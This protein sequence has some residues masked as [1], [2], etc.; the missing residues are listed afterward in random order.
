[1]TD[2]NWTLSFSEL[3]NEQYGSADLAQS[4]LTS[5]AAVYS[6]PPQ[7]PLFKN[8]QFSLEL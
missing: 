1:M 8:T 3:F 4:S 2:M 7:L 6:H 5:P